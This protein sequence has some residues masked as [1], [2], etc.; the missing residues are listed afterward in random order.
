MVFSHIYP[1]RQTLEIQISEDLSYLNRPVIYMFVNLRRKTS[2]V[3]RLIA[4]LA[5]NEEFEYFEI[6]ID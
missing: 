2:S 5:M 6:V 4:L 3:E 1:I